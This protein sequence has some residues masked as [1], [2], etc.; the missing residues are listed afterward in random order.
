[1]FLCLGRVT[2]PKS[3]GIKLLVESYVC[4]LGHYTRSRQDTRDAS[5][6]SSDGKYIKKGSL[7]WSK[8]DVSPAG[9]TMEASSYSTLHKT[10]KH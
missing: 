1:M 3:I 8:S 5:V 6:H 9:G 10:L 4:D 7:G 2:L